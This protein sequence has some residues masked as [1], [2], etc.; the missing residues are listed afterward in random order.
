MIGE[1]CCAIFGKIHSLWYF[2]DACCEANEIKIHF[3]MTWYVCLGPLS[4]THTE[5][6]LQD[7]DLS[8][9]LLQLHVLGLATFVMILCNQVSWFK[10]FLF[11]IKLQGISLLSHWFAF[12]YLTL[13][14]KIVIPSTMHISLD[15]CIVQMLFVCTVKSTV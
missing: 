6:Q 4:F 11:E 1:R 9:E 13:L 3:L 5:K 12:H 7:V 10:C 15:I 8:R 2:L 14:W